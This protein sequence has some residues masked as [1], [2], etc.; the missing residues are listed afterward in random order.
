M[1][2]GV[3]EGAVDGQLGLQ[4]ILRSQEFPFAENRAVMID[5]SGDVVWDYRKAFPILGAET[6]DYD[7]GR[8]S[9]RS[10]TRRTA[11]WPG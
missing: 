9:S 7:G 11:V 10:R 1:E 4:P 5:P 8:R 6:L 3:I 2:I